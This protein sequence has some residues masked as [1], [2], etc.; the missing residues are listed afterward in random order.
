MSGEVASGPNKETFSLGSGMESLLIEAES[1]YRKQG[2]ANREFGEEDV[3]ALLTSFLDSDL[4]KG[5]FGDSLKGIELRSVR[6]PD[7]KVRV[8]VKAL[9]VKLAE[10]F[11]V[12]IRSDVDFDLMI[13]NSD[14][15]PGR[16]IIRADSNT[17][18][19]GDEVN[20][21]L[22]GGK[23]DPKTK[24]RPKPPVDINKVIGDYVRAR[25][26]PYAQVRMRVSNRAI[27]ISINNPHFQ[28]KAFEETIPEPAAPVPQPVPE[29]V[30]AETQSQVTE[31]QDETLPEKAVLPETPVT[32]QAE[33]KPAYILAYEAE[34][35]R[36][37]KALDDELAAVVMDTGEWNLV[38]DAGEKLEAHEAM[39]PEEYA[40]L[41]SIPVDVAPVLDEKAE[42]S[43]TD[44]DKKLE[45]CI[46]HEIREGA[47]FAELIS[48]KEGDDV[49]YILI[50]GKDGKLYFEETDREGT[51]YSRL[52][53]KKVKSYKNLDD[54][55]R[56]VDRN[57]QSFAGNKKNDNLTIQR[58][59]PIFRN[60]TIEE[61]L[62]R[63]R[64]EFE[65]SDVD[66]KHQTYSAKDNTPLTKDI[67]ALRHRHKGRKQPLEKTESERGY[68]SLE[69]VRSTFDDLL[70]A[71][72]N[73]NEFNKSSIHAE[74]PRRHSVFGPSVAERRRKY[75][76]QL[77]STIE[78][79]RTSVLTAF[80]EIDQGMGDRKWSSDE[81][82]L[83]YLDNQNKKTELFQER[84][85]K[86]K[87]EKLSPEE[88][89]VA[90][91]QLDELLKERVKILGL[92][93]SKEIK[94]EKEQKRLEAEK[95]KIESRIKRSKQTRKEQQ[96]VKAEAGLVTNATVQL[97]VSPDRG[98]IKF[99]SKIEVPQEIIDASGKNISDG[100]ATDVDRF[101]VTPEKDRSV[102]KFIEDGQVVYHFVRIR[103]PNARGEGEYELRY[104]ELYEDGEI[105]IDPRNKNQLNEAGVEGAFLRVYSYFLSKQEEGEIKA[106]SFVDLQEEFIKKLAKLNEKFIKRN[107]SRQQS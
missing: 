22:Q 53:A 60:L 61:T 50:W 49:R 89:V 102:L 72:A 56:Y 55:N 27:D 93:T 9:K 32:V 64:L 37:K 5:S 68:D 15:Y 74:D 1:G 73:Y 45:V 40:R 98:D 43:A 42:V 85:R 95:L 41:K 36:L 84:L 66:K 104:F 75:A 2:F 96:A 58:H 51:R 92:R 20:E 14:K 52:K 70:D 46:P 77:D 44:A 80:V 6:I 105:N 39:N 106:L 63:D 28:Q 65:K 78:K 82:Q 18:F 54:L 48:S 34:L 23:I 4:V 17:P 12:A 101:F 10:K 8:G 38:Q 69:I 99:E 25:V 90:L 19:V 7:D 81:E 86:D 100:V 35:A 3:R 29:L 11:G 13:G 31:A 57:V 97:P 91:K 87:F 16:L 33:S 59:L 76:K 21:M 79:H 103:R 67:S 30:Q 83:M 47:E 26:D 94:T 107:R 62:E 71:E 88:K 24:R